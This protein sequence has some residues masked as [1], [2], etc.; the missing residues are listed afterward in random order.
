MITLK[1]VWDKKNVKRSDGT[2]RDEVTTCSRDCAFYGA[3]DAT[4]WCKLK[5][6]KR[7][8]KEKPGETK[9]EEFL[10]STFLN[11]LVPGPDCPGPGEYTLE[12]IVRSPSDKQFLR[13]PGV[14][15]EEEEEEEELK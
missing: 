14:N 3:D 6:S 10:R 2:G 15:A 11:P 12:K 4:H 8:R 5:L 1:I 9:K 7:Y 13:I